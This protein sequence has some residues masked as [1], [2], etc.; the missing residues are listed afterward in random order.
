MVMPFTVLTHYPIVRPFIKK[1]IGRKNLPKPPYI[2]AAN[3]SS[4]F[5]DMVLPFIAYLIAKRKAAIFMNSRFF[6]NKLLKK[7]LMHQGG[8]AIDVAKDVKNEIQRKKTNDKAFDTALKYI[9]HGRIF[10]IFPEGSRSLDG[11]LKK[12]KTGVA[13]IALMAK[14]PVVP[15]G[16]IGSYEMLPKGAKFLR[17]KRATISIGKPLYFDKYYGKEKDYKTL[18][19][20]TATIM[21]EIAKLSNQKWEH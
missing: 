2:L 6:K 18:E 4:Y 3:H 13:K 9:R 21:K 1:V 16:I 20:I 19:N 15:V 10:C 12:A 5:D 17:F 8:I 11:K 7:Y 14:I